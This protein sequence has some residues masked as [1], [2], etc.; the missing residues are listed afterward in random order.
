MLLFSSRTLKNVQ[1]D[2]KAQ[3][4]TLVREILHSHVPCCTVW[5][6]GSRVLGTAK[7]T[8]DLD[9]AILDLPSADSKQID[10]LREAFEESHLPMKVDVLD[11]NKTGESFRR[12]IEKQKIVLQK[13]EVV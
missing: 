2:L 8:S 12:I 5:A 11:W 10:L 3:D 4:L 13:A 7:P 1:L 6:F 9:L